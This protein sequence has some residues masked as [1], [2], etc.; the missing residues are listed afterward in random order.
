MCTPLKLSIEDYMQGMFN[1][2]KQVRKMYIKE[3]EN[4]QMMHIV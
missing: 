1:H 2:S 3:F 4:S